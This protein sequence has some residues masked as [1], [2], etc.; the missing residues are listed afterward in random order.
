MSRK[1]RERLVIF[2]QIR[3]TEGD[4]TEW[5]SFLTPLLFWVKK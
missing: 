1:E 2:N 4:T 5:H 3:L